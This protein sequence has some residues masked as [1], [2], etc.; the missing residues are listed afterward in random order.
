MNSITN[1]YKDKKVVLFTVIG[2]DKV[3]EKINQIEVVNIRIDEK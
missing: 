2:Q 3:I 1:L